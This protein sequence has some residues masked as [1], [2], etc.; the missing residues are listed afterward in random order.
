MEEYQDAYR[1]SIEQPELFWANIAS[2]FKW[3]KAPYG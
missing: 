1:L 3:K 2:H